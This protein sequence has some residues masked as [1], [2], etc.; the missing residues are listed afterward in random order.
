M[1]LLTVEICPEQS[2]ADAGGEKPRFNEDE[3]GFCRFWYLGRGGIHSMSPLIDI[4][5]ITLDIILLPL[6]EYK[7]GVPSECD[8]SE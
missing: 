7:Q 4:T 1:G 3:N 6:Y 5:C 8:I 2:T